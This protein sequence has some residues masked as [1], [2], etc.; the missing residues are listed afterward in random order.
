[1]TWPTPIFDIKIVLDCV[2]QSGSSHA[3]R[4]CRSK[5]IVIGDRKLCWKPLFLE[6]LSDDW[7]AIGAIKCMYRMSTWHI[8]IYASFV[9]LLF[10]QTKSADC[11]LSLRYWIY[12]FDNVSMWIGF[13]LTWN[14]TL[15]NLDFD[16]IAYF[17][18]ILLLLVN[19]QIHSN[20]PR[21]RKNKMV[22][23]I[24]SLN[25]TLNCSIAN[26]FSFPWILICYTHCAWPTLLRMKRSC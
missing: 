19:E 8:A 23:I 14:S 20:S 21:K 24:K 1:M 4:N 26:Q 17:L 3:S 11:A 13:L 16:L 10:L 18:C 5:Q 22:V 6:N 25:V 15:D 7:S 2:I 12:Y 9:L